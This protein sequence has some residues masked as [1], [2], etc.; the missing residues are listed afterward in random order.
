[1]QKILTFGILALFANGVSAEDFRTDT[2]VSLIRFYLYTRQNPGLQE[3]DELFVDDAESIINSHFDVAK[4][5]KIVAHGFS[6]GPFTS[7]AA[8]V[9]REAYL[10]KGRLVYRVTHHIDSNLP[11]TSKQKVHFGLTRSG[12]FALMSTRGL[13]QRN[14][15]PCMTVWTIVRMFNFTSII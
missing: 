11:L 8:I 7:N 10:E 15:P 9:L 4:K 2:N 6:S 3:Y 1:M 5:T 13:N 12:T 14:V